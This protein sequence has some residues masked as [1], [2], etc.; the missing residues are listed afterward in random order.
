M[1]WSCVCILRGYKYGADGDVGQDIYMLHDSQSLDSQRAAVP[2][3]EGLI[4][5]RGLMSSF[6]FWKFNWRL[7]ERSYSHFDPQLFNDLLEQQVPIISKI[8]I[9]IKRIDGQCFFGYSVTGIC[10]LSYLCVFFKLL[11][12]T[13]FLVVSYLTKN[14]VF[15][16]DSIYSEN[17]VMKTKKRLVIIKAFYLF[18]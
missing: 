4:S 1:V 9:K 5:E 17:H 11:T 16:W 12:I 14:N 6:I 8:Q 2:M 13:C 10:F 15:M 18:I 3:W 7:V